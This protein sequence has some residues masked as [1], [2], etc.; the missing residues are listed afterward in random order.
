MIAVLGLGFVGLTT[1]LGF[2]KKGFRV[3]GFDVDKTKA[4]VIA[5][6]KIPFFEADMQEVLDEQL[7]HNFTVSDTLADAVSNSKVIFLCVGTPSDEKGKADLTYL[8]TAVGD[9]L[10]SVFKRD[11]RK[12][13]SSNRPFPHRRRG[14]MLFRSLN[15]KDSKSVKTSLSRTTPNFCAKVMLGKTLS[16]PTAL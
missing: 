2:S 8:L 12:S 10:K 11:R 3:R 1:A 15:Q 5:S 16:N 14:I 4:S 13:S 9:I 7:N 6:G